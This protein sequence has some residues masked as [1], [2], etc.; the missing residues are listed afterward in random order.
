[1]SD[2]LRKIY[3]DPAVRAVV[4]TAIFTGYYEDE[5][6]LLSDLLHPETSPVFKTA[7]Y[8]ALKSKAGVNF[9][10]NLFAQRF[11][12]AANRSNPRAR[13][14]DEDDLYWTTPGGY[15]IYFP[16]SEVHLGRADYDI[17][18]VA[19]TEDGDSK[20]VTDPRCDDTPRNYRYCSQT[21]LVDDDYAESYPV[22]IVGVGAEPAARIAQTPKPGP[23]FL[24]KIG[25]MRCI[26]Q[27]DHLIGTRNSGGSE[28]KVVRGS[29]YLKLEN[30]QITAP[31]DV[32]NATSVMGRQRGVFTR[33]SIKYQKWQPQGTIW[34]YDWEEKNLEQVLGVYEE[35]NQGEQT[36]SGSLTTTLTA[37]VAPA[38]ASTV[39][40]PIGY[41]LKVVTQDDII[42]NRKIPRDAYFYGAK[43]DLENA[44]FIDGWPIRD[45]NQYVSYTLPYQIY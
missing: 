37:G 17:V 38:T 14:T 24:V 18:V 45:Y 31:E 10:D 9:E 40:G 23:Y 41:S 35:D 39:I 7:N 28:I 36:F 4:N 20:Y 2:I 15:N 21:V 44:G 13:T 34:D 29:G 19:A 22:H 43:T 30:G 3:R 5:R 42:I 27:F 33:Y 1:M 8:Q 11:R 6:V 32:F 12:A 26:K 25:Y 16:Y